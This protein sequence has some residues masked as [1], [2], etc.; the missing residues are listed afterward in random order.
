[1]VV[2][3]LITLSNVMN[4][5]N[6]LTTTNKL[7]IRIVYKDRLVTSR[8]YHNINETFIFLAYHSILTTK[9]LLLDF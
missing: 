8:T 3:G 2:Y 7:S 9:C 5:D 6:R 4:N 1:M